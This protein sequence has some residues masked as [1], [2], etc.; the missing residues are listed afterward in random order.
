[1][2]DL[3]KAFHAACLDAISECRRI[4]YNPT[5]WTRMVAEYGGVVT[6]RRLINSGDIQDGLKKLLGLGRPDLTVESLIL[7]E[8]W[9][10]LFS[11]EERELAQ[12]RLNQAQGLR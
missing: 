1:M 4:G 10:E 12:W 3:D 8:E 5:V 9:L 6:A 11:D 2:N 7:R